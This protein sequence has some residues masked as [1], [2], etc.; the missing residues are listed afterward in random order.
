MADNFSEKLIF[1]NFFFPK[2][3]RHFVILVYIKNRVI[4]AI[5]NI[6]NLKPFDIFISDDSSPKLHQQRR[7]FSSIKSYQNK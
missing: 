5:A 1:R 2:N 7:L 6:L 4:C 3:V